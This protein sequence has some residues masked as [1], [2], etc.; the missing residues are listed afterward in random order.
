MILAREKIDYQAPE[1]Q[2]TQQPKQA[3]WPQATQPQAAQ[4][5]RQQPRRQ[6]MIRYKLLLIAMVCCCFVMGTMVAYYYAQVSYV[7][8]KIDNLQNSLADLRIESHGLE[9]DITRIV[10]LGQIEHVAV[11][12]LGMVKP[13]YD[14]AILIAS[15]SIQSKSGESAQQGTSR[16]QSQA[17]DSVLPAV[18]QGSAQQQN[19]IIQAF[20]QMVEKYN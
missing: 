14:Q 6:Q 17:E 11:N 5:Q 20:T 9:Q 3:A 12:Q 19:K 15:H 13:D 10:S 7:G 16:G 8:Y 18:E 1:Q 2:W 4:R